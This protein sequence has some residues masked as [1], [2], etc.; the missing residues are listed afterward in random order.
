MQKV[1]PQR[2][3]SASKVP[4]GT[5]TCFNNEQ[6]RATNDSKSDSEGVFIG[7]SYIEP[8][9]CAD[10]ENIFKIDTNNARDNAQNEQKTLC[11][12]GRR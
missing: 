11:E 3:Q 10:T 5:Q 6:K 12:N 4:P 7:N 2:S 9:M 1:S 8:Q